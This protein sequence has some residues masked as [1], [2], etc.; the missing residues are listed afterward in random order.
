MRTA[1]CAHGE[2][3]R[4]AEADVSAARLAMRH[5]FAASGVLPVDG[6]LVRMSPAKWK[7]G[8]AGRGVKPASAHSL[9]RIRGDARTQRGQ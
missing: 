1:E 6:R 9:R 5:G 7:G 4:R 3:R 8:A 2:K